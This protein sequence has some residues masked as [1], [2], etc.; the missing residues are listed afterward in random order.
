MYYLGFVVTHADVFV[1]LINYYNLRI[2]L[3]SLNY[4]GEYYLIYYILYIILEYYILE[5]YI[6]YILKY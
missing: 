4:T 6:L 3:Q 1:Y 2:L 5:Y